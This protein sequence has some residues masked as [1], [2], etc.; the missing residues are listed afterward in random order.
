MRSTTGA[1]N[2]FLLQGR[3][4]QMPDWEGN[5]VQA[6]RLTS[7]AMKEEDRSNIE[8]QHSSKTVLQIVYQGKYLKIDSQTRLALD[9]F[10]L[11]FPKKYEGGNVTQVIIT[12]QDSEM[13]VVVNGTAE[14][15]FIQ[16]VIPDEFKGYVEGLLGNWDEV[17]DNDLTSNGGT[18]V[19]PNATAE[20]IYNQFGKSWEINPVDSLFLYD[21]GQ[22]H[23]YFQDNDF[24]PDFTAPDG[25]LPT[26]LDSQTVVDTCDGNTY[27][28]YDI[29]STGLLQLG[30]ATKKAYDDY[31]QAQRA[32]RDL[33]T[34]Q[35]IMTPKNGTKTFLREKNHLVGSE[36]EFRC[37]DDFIPIGPEYR[38][39][40]STGDWSGGAQE[41]DIVNECLESLL[42][43][44]LETPIH[45][46]I[47]AVD[48]APERIE[49]AYSCDIG[50]ERYGNQYRHCRQEYEHWTGYKPGCYQ[51]LNPLELA[52]AIV[53]GVVGAILLVAAAIFIF[54][55]AAKKD[56]KDDRL[57]R[58]KEMFSDIEMKTTPAT[59]S[60][61]HRGPPPSQEKPGLSYGTGASREPSPYR[62]TPDPVSYRPVPQHQ[63]TPY[64]PA[65]GHPAHPPAAAN[66]PPPA[67]VHQ[68]DVEQENKGYASESWA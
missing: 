48:R 35:Y 34:C 32:L 4:E 44:G 3:T 21:Q 23:D 29:Q 58:E 2:R 11:S 60:G 45:G 15:M 49:V 42:C 43:G 6:T 61:Y 14:G 36:L 67:P 1:Q 25:N 8:I 51:Q 5:R 57:K 16:V 10:Y 46:S 18:S 17:P 62:A 26:Y 68:A 65:G 22:N 9:G 31:K 55:W 40:Q 19:D 7:V 47:S 66:Y 52:M 24:V 33:T 38:V 20:V 27:C 28:I 13:G 59:Q 41:D 56:R 64:P 39:C 53:G 30:K 50:Y 63:T 37:D 12:F 54:L